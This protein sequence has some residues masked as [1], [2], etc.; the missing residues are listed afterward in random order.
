MDTYTIHTTWM[1]QY[2]TDYKKKKKINGLFLGLFLRV[3]LFET[4]KEWRSLWSYGVRRAWRD[5]FLMSLTR[6]LTCS[7]LTRIFCGV[8]TVDS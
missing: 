8:H 2:L 4:D 1:D 6:T 5:V 3:D 7:S